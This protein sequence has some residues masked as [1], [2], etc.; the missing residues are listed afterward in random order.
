METLDAVGR[1]N[2]VVGS[3]KLEGKRGREERPRC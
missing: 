1:E 2:N 3:R